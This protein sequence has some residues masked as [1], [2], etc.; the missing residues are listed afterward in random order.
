MVESFFK[1]GLL[2][3][4]IE[5]KLI[6][7]RCVNPRDFSD[8]PHYRVDDKPYGG[9]AGMVLKIEPL[10]R[11]LRAI[12]TPAQK[13]LVMSA[14]GTTFSQQKAVAYSKEE[15]LIVVCGRY[16]G[17][18]QRFIDYYADEEIRVGDA[19][20]M[21][22]EAAALAIIEAV[23]R[24]IPGVLG[25]AASLTVE[26]NT[27]EGIEEYPQYTRPPDFEGHQVPEVLQNGDHKKIAEWRAR[28][29]VIRAK[30]EGQ[31]A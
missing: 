15:H 30:G 29:Q 26:T 7:I 19:V 21:G 28:E 13:V 25:N 22:G 10:V 8:P 23:A 6:A 4:A 18:D 31:N 27:A 24:L 9:G 1:E 2:S 5:K 20:T 11:A 12:A 3:K 16:E 14:K 17:I